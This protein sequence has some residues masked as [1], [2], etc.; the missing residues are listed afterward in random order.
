MDG[1]SDCK[2]Q[3]IEAAERDAIQTLQNA[4][5]EST[6][7]RKECL[8]RLGWISWLRFTA[9]LKRDNQSE[10]HYRFYGRAFNFYESALSLTPEDDLGSLHSL[11]KALGKI[12][13]AGGQFEQSEKQFN[14]ALRCSEMLGD[15]SSTAKV[16]LLLAHLYQ[17][18]G[19]IEE[20][21][22]T[23]TAACQD[24]G[25]TGEGE[26]MNLCRQFLT[27]IKIALKQA[28]PNR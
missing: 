7:L 10:E 6:L 5:P 22:Q 28:A 27:N 25:K 11:H 3:D 18:A 4:Q 19:R 20:A 21:L 17:Q 13:L 12:Y 24:L 8:E 23:A 1:A 26:W 15:L 16:R 2:L 14:E 9:A